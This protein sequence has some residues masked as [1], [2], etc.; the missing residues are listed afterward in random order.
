MSA[1]QNLQ[2]SEPLAN[3][4]KSDDLLPAE[5]HIHVEIQQR[6]KDPCYFQEFTDDYKEKKLVKVLKKKAAY[7]GDVTEH[8]QYGEVSCRM[9][10]AST[11]TS[12]S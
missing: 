1:I 12:S 2:P 5:N 10:S 11:Y 6:G 3:A 8:P 9:T 7:N 4:N